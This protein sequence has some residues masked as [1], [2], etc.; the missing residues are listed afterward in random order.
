MSYLP[1]L[2]KSLMVSVVASGLWVAGLALLLAAFSYH[3]DQA[4][5]QH[6]PLSTQLNQCS[7]A[8][9]LWASFTLVALGLA[10]TSQTWWEAI[11]WSVFSL[12]T[13]YQMITRWRTMA[14][15]ED[16]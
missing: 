13:F 7:F 5:Q 15:A 9:A 2:R 8:T 6:R 1:L 4:R 11:L 10:A 3:Y 16:G 14:R 12:V